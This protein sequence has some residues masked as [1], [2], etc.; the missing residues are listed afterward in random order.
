MNKEDLIS[1]V[2][3]NYELSGMQILVEITAKLN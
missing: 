1:D 3:F 2:N